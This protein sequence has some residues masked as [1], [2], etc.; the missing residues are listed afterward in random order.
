MMKVLHVTPTYAPSI[1][2]IEEVVANLARLGRRAGMQADVAHVAPGLGHSERRQ[3]SF[4]VWT[5]PL[6]GHRM[7]GWAPALARLASR[8]DLLHV[9]DPQVGALTLNIGGAAARVPAVLST[10]GGFFHT[11]SAAMAKQFHARFTA[12]RML[13]RYARIMAS[14]HTDLARFG[15]LSPNVVLMENGVDTARL[16]PASVASHR[17]LHRWVFWG[18]FAR[19]KRIDSLIHLVAALASHGII[20]DLALCGTDFDGSLATARNLV[21]SLELERQVSFHIGLNDAALRA[22]IAT[23]AVF[24]LPSEYEGFGLSIIEA[25]AA[26]LIPLCR[27]IAPMNVLAGGAAV[28]LAFDGGAGD[29][30]QVRE[31]LATPPAGIHARRHVAA[32]RAASFDW[33]ARFDAFL[34]Q[35]RQCAGASPSMRH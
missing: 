24:A 15:Q 33:A 19:N 14:S 8:Y 21:A 31:L 23:R 35:Y 2:G 25:M 9:H 17:D 7:L 12:P 29:V 10:H 20:I 18:R 28:L 32:T 11:Q 16:S 4:S 6:V 26:G 22:E 1:G 27:D 3:E 13:R 30:R 34:Q 5:M